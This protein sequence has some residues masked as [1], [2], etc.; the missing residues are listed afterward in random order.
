MFSGRVDA[1]IR[2]SN[3]DVTVRDAV[4]NAWSEAIGTIWI[5]SVPMAGFALI[6]TLFLREYSLDRKI[7]RGDEA[8]T[9]GDLERDA[10][11]K[12]EGDL[13]GLKPLDDD[14]EMTPTNCVA[15]PE[16]EQADLEKMET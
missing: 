14:P 15:H 11:P 16:E 13:Q 1:N 4:L 10:V 5:M 9:T 3:Q 2:Q 6:L 12:D 7:V 8:K